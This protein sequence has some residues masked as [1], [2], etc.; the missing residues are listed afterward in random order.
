M[1]MSTSNPTIDISRS[2]YPYCLVWGPL[3]LITW[4]FP[5]IGH[6][7]IADSQGRVHDFA[8]PYT[9][10]IDRFMV[11]IARY[12]P[13]HIERERDT[14]DTDQRNDHERWK[15]R[16]TDKN[17]E[18]MLNVS[19]DEAIAR[20]DDAYG[21]TSHNLITNNCHHHVASACQSMGLNSYSSLLR[22]WWEMMKHGEYVST[23]ARIGVWAPAIVIW[24]TVIVLICVL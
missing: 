5:F 20:A 12:L 19:W 6:L 7:G 18:R 1:R 13:L 21:Q 9:I 17:N 15:E 24:S 2:R 8:G 3:P 11:S 23:G 10:G 22:V 16:L 4:L 14:N